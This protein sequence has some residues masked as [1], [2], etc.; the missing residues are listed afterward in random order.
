MFAR[1]NNPLLSF[2]LLYEI[3]LSLSLK[4]FSL[5]N[6]CKGLMAKIIEACLIYI[7]CVDDENFL[8]TI[9]LER[10]FSGRDPLRIAVELELLEL[11]Q[12]PKVE[13][14]I[15]RIYNS[16]YKQSGSLFEMSTSY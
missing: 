4:F 7:D 10:D 3:M 2:V 12:N 15:K 6:M 14:I 11:I 5:S 13:A 1:S 16:D 8:T 9:M